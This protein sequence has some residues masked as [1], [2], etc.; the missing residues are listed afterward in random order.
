YEVSRVTMCR[1][2]QIPPDLVVKYQGVDI[3]EVISSLILRR[4]IV[5]TSCRNRKWRCGPL[6]PSEAHRSTTKFSGMWN[7]HRDQQSVVD[8]F[9]LLGQIPRSLL[10]LFPGCYRRCY[11]RL[12][13]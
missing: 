11:E 4:N 3:V 2:C 8:H 6:S 13:T 7:V 1:N 5:R 12:S 9:N 10:R